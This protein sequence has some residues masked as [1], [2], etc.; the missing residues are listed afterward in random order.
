MKTMETPCIQVC[1]LNPEGLCTGCYRTIAEITGWSGFT[2]AERHRIMGELPRRKTAM[3][4]GME[5]ARA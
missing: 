4:T 3:A 5:S 2:A 1:Q